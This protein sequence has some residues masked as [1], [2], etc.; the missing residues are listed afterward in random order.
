MQ[1]RLSLLHGTTIQRMDLVD[2]VDNGTV[3]DFGEHDVLVVL[4]EAKARRAE[5]LAARRAKRLAAAREA[6]RE[7]FRTA[8]LA[9]SS[10]EE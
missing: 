8:A 2:D 3:V 7:A 4:T 9:P 1:L 6:R 5:K 10:D